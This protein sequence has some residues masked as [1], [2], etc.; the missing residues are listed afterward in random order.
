MIITANVF[1]DSSN[2]NQYIMTT[3][4]ESKEEENINGQQITDPWE[5]G[6]TED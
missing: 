2:L 1:V 3:N 6:R 5:T 4:S